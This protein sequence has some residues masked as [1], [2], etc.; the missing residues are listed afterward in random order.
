MTTR[1]A[2][3]LVVLAVLV[4]MVLLL[5]CGQTSSP[6]PAGVPVRVV[7]TIPP[8]ESFVKNVAGPH[9]AVRCLCTGTGPHHYEYN[10]QDLQ[11]FREANLFFAVG[12]TLDN[13]F[14]DALHA[15]AKNPGLA[16]RKLGD[17]LPDKLKIRDEDHDE[18]DK[19][20]EKEKGKE[21][22]GHEHGE[23]DP[24]VWLGIET[25]IVMV[26]KIRDELKGVD[27]AHAGDYDTNA[28]KYI[29]TLKKLHADGRAQL[30]G[31]KNKKIVSFHESLPYF[32]KSFG[33]EIVDVIEQTAGDN[34]TGRKLTKLVEKCKKEDVQ[35]IAVE[36][37][38]PGS[39]AAKTLHDELAKPA[40][41]L[42]VKLV[43]VDPL[44]T[45]DA[46]E[47]EDPGWYEAKMRRNV[48]E[49]AKALP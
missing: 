49:L 5:G 11:Q 32:A 39:G 37:Q 8:L 1:R 17:L 13:K 6:W 28:K 30:E 4:P 3:S 2:L 19:D 22:H 16:Y 12:L 35:V 43:E 15:N 26:E 48:E 46:K 36:P 9:A 45:A 20:K 34:P 18:H 33:I 40:I 14:A 29:E 31:K 44:E 10:V 38:Y 7:V 42:K 27:A 24:H 25:A 21:E 41:N 23:I 47:L